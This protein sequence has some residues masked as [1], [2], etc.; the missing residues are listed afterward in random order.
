MRMWILAIGLLII[1]LISP[2]F[3]GVIGDT[4]G[5]YSDPVTQII[6]YAMIPVFVFLYAFVKLFFSEGK[7]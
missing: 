6:L 5:M 3:A 2:L 7:Q 4:V 1:G